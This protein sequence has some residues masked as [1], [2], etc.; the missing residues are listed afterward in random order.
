VLL[1]Q[2]VEKEAIQH[3]SETKTMLK[4]LSPP[5]H[6]VPLPSRNYS[7]P[8]LHHHSPLL[9]L[10]EALHHHHHHYYDQNSPFS[11]AP[12]AASSP[13]LPSATESPPSSSQ[14]TPVEYPS[15]SPVHPT[16]WSITPLQIPLPPF[17]P[18]ILLDPIVPCV[19]LHPVHTMLHHPHYYLH[20]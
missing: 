6:D 10:L 13:A 20:Q 16:S 15:D 7:F 11:A 17:H 14:S 12:A 3:H 4:Q 19:D 5:Q 1:Q 2:E 8:D 18:R 9:L